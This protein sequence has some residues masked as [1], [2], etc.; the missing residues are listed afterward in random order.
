MD[1]HE[2]AERTVCGRA[3][4]AM[5]SPKIRQTRRGR[6]RFTSTLP[7]SC[8]SCSYICNWVVTH[9]VVVTGAMMGVQ[10]SEDV[11][12]VMLRLYLDSVPHFYKYV[13]FWKKCFFLLYNRIY[14]QEK[15]NFNSIY[16]PTAVT[17]FLNEAAGQP[18][19]DSSRV[20]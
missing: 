2:H 20:H 10:R 12:N 1:V 11:L 6:T 18:T 15:K 19:Q 13:S 7:A 4:T 14:L 9:H 16:F 5:L 3:M 8:V 17:V